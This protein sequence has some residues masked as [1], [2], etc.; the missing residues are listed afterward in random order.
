MRIARDGVRRILTLS[1]ARLENVVVVIEVLDVGRAEGVVLRLGA[2]LV[3][4]LVGLVVHLDLVLPRPG[5][6]PLLVEALAERLAVLERQAARAR[7][8]R[9]A[10][11]RARRG[12]LPERRDFLQVDHVDRDVAQVVRHADL[13]GERRATS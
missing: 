2:R 4:R 11:H 1:G 10:A 5:R 3:V 9:H 12:R 7:A 6:R 8:V 13:S